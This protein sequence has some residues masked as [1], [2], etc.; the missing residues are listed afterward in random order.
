M[1]GVSHLVVDGGTAAEKYHAGSI[2]QSIA[3]RNLGQVV[4]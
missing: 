3:M 1:K 2:C 4:D